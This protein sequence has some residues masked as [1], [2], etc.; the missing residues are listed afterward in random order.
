MIGPY[1]HIACC[2]ETSSAI[3]LILSE[4]DR[5]RELGE[6]R[7]SLV[8]VV[9]PPEAYRFDPGVAHEVDLAE[10][11]VGRKWLEAQCERARGAEPVLLEGHPASAVSEW[12]KG[13]GVDLIVASAHRDAVERNE[14]GGFAGELV[15]TSPATL[16]LVRPPR[17]S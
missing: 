12:A 17:V 7:V 8:H 14:L 3:D 5:L 6:S 1:V 11:L 13:A 16:H 9:E 2:V 10:Q 4:L 15:Y